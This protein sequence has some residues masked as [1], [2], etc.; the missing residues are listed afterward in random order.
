MA[1][2]FIAEV[3]IFGFDFAP[4]GWAFCD[5]QLM[6]IQ[7]NTALFAL[8]GTTYGG[9]GTTNF[10]LP[11]LQ[12]R[13]ALHPGQGQGL[14]HRQRGESLGAESVTLLESQMPAHS[15]GTRASTEDG[16]LKMPAADRI[17]GGSVGAHAYQ[18]SAV[19]T[20]PMAPQAIAQAGGSLPHDNMMPYLTLHFCIALQGVFP[21]RH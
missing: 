2:P 5:G 13:A 18:S 19:A 8:L 1:D 15:H 20:V 6:P 11:D 4:T 17:L 9:N 10:A 3:R 7:Q 14:S 16:E 12:G 21:P